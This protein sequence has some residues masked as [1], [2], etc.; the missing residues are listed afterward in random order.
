MATT[1]LTDEEIESRLAAL[2]GWAR[3]GDTLT[4]TYK[5]ETYTDGLAFATAAGIV[6]EGKDHHPDIVIGWRKVALVFT[7]HDADSKI[8]SF[9]TDAASAIEALGFPKAK[10]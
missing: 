2:P 3:N 4:K 8:T 1:P 10:A 7:T 6:A 5:F 9:D